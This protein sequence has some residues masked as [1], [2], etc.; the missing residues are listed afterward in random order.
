MFDELPTTDPRPL[1]PLLLEAPLLLP[2]AR[3]SAP[4]LTLTN[5]CRD[6]PMRAASS[7]AHLV[8]ARPLLG[9][10]LCS[11][12]ALALRFSLLERLCG[13]SGLLTLL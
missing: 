3:A 11:D 8:K 4:M 9:G 12:D 5:S 13:W 1:L 6:W 10:P 7:M 2:S